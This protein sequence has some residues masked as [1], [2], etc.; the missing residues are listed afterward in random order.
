MLGPRFLSVEIMVEQW[1]GND[2]E[3]TLPSSAL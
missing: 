2:S 3:G 1:L